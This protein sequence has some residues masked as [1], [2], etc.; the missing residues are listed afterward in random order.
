MIPKLAEGQEPLRWIAS[1]IYNTLAFPLS[2]HKVLTK[3]GS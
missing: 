2:M 1:L 3:Q